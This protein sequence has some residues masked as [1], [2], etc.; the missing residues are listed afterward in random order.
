MK[1]AR[2]LVL[3]F[4]VTGLLAVL[5]AC[6]SGSPSNVDNS[7]PAVTLS[8]SSYDTVKTG[9]VITIKAQDRESGIQSIG[10]WWG[11]AAIGSVSYSDSEISMDQVEFKVILGAAV[12]PGQEYKLTVKAINGAGLV[13]ERLISLYGLN[14]DA[15]AGEP[16]APSVPICTGPDG[17]P[18]AIE[19]A[20]R[21]PLL[22]TV[23]S[24]TIDLEFRIFNRQCVERVVFTLIL[25][26]DSQRIALEE[27]SDA[28]V[29]VGTLDTAP[30]T[31]G[32]YKLA[33]TIYPKYGS[34]LE[35]VELSLQIA[36]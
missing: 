35:T 36:D 34:E 4:L 18:E 23:A 30:Y 25:D 12:A 29:Y 14:P 16:G 27:T 3:A 13:N 11:E 7:R 19:A 5:A 28:G 21:L 9:D 1:F 31:A 20:W 22:G 24:G 17:N 6:D 32:D 33:A 8:V 10:V 26:P 15:R 2:T